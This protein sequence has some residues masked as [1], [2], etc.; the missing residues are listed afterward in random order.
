MS[1]E[2]YHKYMLYDQALTKLSDENADLRIQLQ[3]IG[4]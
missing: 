4:T 3:R 2:V 1:E